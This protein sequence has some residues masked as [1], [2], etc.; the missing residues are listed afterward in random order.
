MC[1][2]DLS[3]LDVARIAAGC[4]GETCRDRVLEA[5]RLLKAAEE[6]AKPDLWEN[7][8][9]V[10]DAEAD[11]VDNRYIQRRKQAVEI[12]SESVTS[13]GVPRKEVL[14]KV[15][16]LCGRSGD[17]SA[18]GKAYMKWA[19]AAEEELAEFRAWCDYVS[20]NPEKNSP[21]T[22]V[23]W[24]KK[25]KS[26]HSK[27]DGYEFLEHYEKPC[28]K[29]SA[30]YFKSE[31]MAV[32]ALAGDGTG[33][34]IPL[35]EYWMNPKGRKLLHDPATKKFVRHGDRKNSPSK[36]NTKNENFS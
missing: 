21:E 12:V 25:W 20:K 15:Y 9:S 16:K 10:E 1:S 3:V 8:S 5:M 26:T 13:N 18:Q 27:F 4:V 6:I 11:A 30:A 33:N 19:S 31:E 14:A 24:W 29:G 17:S 2:S 32:T 7:P 35:L 22:S 28:A 34:F 23:A 36:K